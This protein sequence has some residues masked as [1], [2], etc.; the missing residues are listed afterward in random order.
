MNERTDQVDDT[1]GYSRVA[2]LKD[3]FHRAVRYPDRYAWYVLA[4]TLDIMTTVLVLT[5]LGFREANSFA[6]KSI[7]YFGTW[8][9]IGLKFVSVIIVVAI[10]E[11]VGRRREDLGRRVATLAIIASLFPVLFAIAQIVYAWHRGVLV[12]EDGPRHHHE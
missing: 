10:C 5:H 12:I 8:G 2:A 11:F 7:D 4:S 9:L 6:Q 1:P 3:F